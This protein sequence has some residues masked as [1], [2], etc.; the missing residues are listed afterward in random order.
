M[1]FNA[2]AEKIHLQ[3]G[4]KLIIV[5][6]DGGEHTSHDYIHKPALDGVKPNLIVL[7]T[8]QQD[9]VAETSNKIIVNDTN[10]MI[11]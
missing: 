7:Y 9:G 11:K 1:L 2:R 8:P 6:R 3:K 4:C 10:A 5:Q